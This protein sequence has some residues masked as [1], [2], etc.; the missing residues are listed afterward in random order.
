M[1]IYPRRL[2]D[3]SWQELANCRTTDPEQFFPAVSEETAATVRMAKLI[4]SQCDVQVQCLRYALDSG[5]PFGI[6]GGMTPRERHALR[7]YPA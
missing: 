6:W 4:C 7:E 1:K 3:M 2:P 5:E